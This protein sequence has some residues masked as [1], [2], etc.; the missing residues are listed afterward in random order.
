MIEWK[1]FDRTNPHLRLISRRVEG[2]AQLLSSEAEKPISF[3]SLDCI[4]YFEDPDR[5]RYGLI[6]SPLPAMA[7]TTLPVSSHDILLRSSPGL[8]PH[9]GDRFRMAEKIATSVIRLHDCSW[10]HAALRSSYIL[11]F[12]NTND[13]LANVSPENIHLNSP[14]VTG[15]TYS[16]PSDPAESTLEYSQL[17]QSSD[18]GLYRHPS[19]QRSNVA[20]FGNATSAE[21]VR[22]RQR[23]DLFSLGIILLGIGLWEQVVQLWKE[24]YTPEKFLEKLLTAYVPALGHKMGAIYRDVVWELLAGDGTSLAAARREVRADEPPVGGGT[25]L[26]KLSMADS[27]GEET[28]ADDL[29]PDAD[30]MGNAWA[31]LISTLLLTT[32]DGHLWQYSGCQACPMQSGSR[33][34]F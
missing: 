32:R 23:H 7:Q 16:R 9:L 26:E 24:K 27:E 11:F 4:G 15:F 13:R 3:R 1:D 30:F 14:Y 31:N 12:Y 17:Q 6:F 10:V 21:H 8:L 25:E 2:L 19:I 34:C 29:P 28:D 33:Y 22:F 20:M 5:P 18:H